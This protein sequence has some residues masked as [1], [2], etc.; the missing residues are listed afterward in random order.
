MSKPKIVIVDCEDG[1]RLKVDLSKCD[2]VLGKDTEYFGAGRDLLG[3][4]R[5]GSTVIVGT[6]SRW[7]NGRGGCFGDSYH[8]ADAEEIAGF[9]READE[10]L[11]LVPELV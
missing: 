3:V 11:D 6:Y 1:R 7:D 5:K 8:V 4:W 9:A 2:E 10:L